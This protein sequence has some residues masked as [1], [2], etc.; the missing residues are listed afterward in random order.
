VVGTIAPTVRPIADAAND[1][2]VTIPQ[3][4]PNLESTSPNSVTSSIVTAINIAFPN[5]K[6]VFS[7]FYFH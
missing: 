2:A 4:F 5:L 6:E 1:S 3:N 7:V